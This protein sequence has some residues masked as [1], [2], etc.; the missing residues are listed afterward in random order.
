MLIRQG[1]V[2]VDKGC[3]PNRSHTSALGLTKVR[4]A[5]RA[6]KGVDKELEMPGLVLNRL[7]I[8]SLS[9]R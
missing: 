3:G 4:G 7:P 8:N 9:C 5:P 6:P 1:G 2:D